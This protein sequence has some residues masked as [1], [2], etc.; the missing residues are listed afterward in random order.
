MNKHVHGLDQAKALSSRGMFDQI[1][2]LAQSEGA[3]GDEDLLTLVDE[4]Y[5][6]GARAE[7]ERNAFAEVHESMKEPPYGCS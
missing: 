1:D 5:T 3:T 6:V 4:Y 2:W 7:G